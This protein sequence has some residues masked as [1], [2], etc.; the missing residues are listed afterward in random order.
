MAGE[1]IY[2]AH[3]AMFRAHPFWFILFVLLI[4]AF[5]IGL[6]ILLYWYITTRAT[7]HIIHVIRGRRARKADSRPSGIAGRS[8]SVAGAVVF[9]AITCARGRWSSVTCPSRG[10]S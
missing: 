4:A 8:S 3:P 9:R 5:G 2:E 6:L 7:A 1:V 10:M